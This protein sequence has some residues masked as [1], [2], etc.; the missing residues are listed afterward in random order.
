MRLNV[1]RG[2]T[3]EELDH[4]VEVLTELATMGGILGGDR[5]PT[6]STAD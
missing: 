5:A 1:T 2:H 3:Y 6:E 4:A